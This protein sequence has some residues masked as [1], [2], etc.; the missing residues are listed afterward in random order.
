MTGIASASESAT[1]RLLARARS[2]PPPATMTPRSEAASHLMA[3][4]TVA[5]SGAGRRIA[6]GR[7]DRALDRLGQA[8]SGSA[9]RTGPGRPVSE[10]AS[11]SRTSVVRV[12]SSSWTAH[13]ASRPMP[14]TRSD[15]WNA[16]RPRSRRSTWPTRAI[17]GAESW[18]A[19]W[20]PMAAFA[21]PTVRVTRTSWGRPVDC[22]SA[23]AMKAALALVARRDDADAS[24][25]QVVDERQEALARHREAEP[26]TEGV[27]LARDLGGHRGRLGWRIGLLRTRRLGLGLGALARARERSPPARA[28]HPPERA[29]DPL[30]RQLVQVRLG[31]GRHVDHDRFDRLRPLRHAR[32]ALLGVSHGRSVI[33][34]GPSSRSGRARSATQGQPRTRR[35]T[36]SVSSRP[37]QR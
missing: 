18:L 17:R 8:S 36:R 24:R 26:G 15:S 13:A 4:R 20:M 35:P 21:A 12:G 7:A 31:L 37:A 9:S 1:S 22:A 14:P 19:A 32:A 30:P 29:R 16:S 27:Q 28:R 2:T 34:V 11:S 10:V 3:V 23:S 5:R 25:R 33:N 6:G